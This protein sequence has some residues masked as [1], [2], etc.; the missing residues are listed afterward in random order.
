MSRLLILTAALATTLFA[1]SASAATFDANSWRADRHSVWVPG[2]DQRHLHFT[3]G[4]TFDVQP[5]AWHLEGNLVSGTDGSH[6]Q[7]SVDFSDILTGDEF[8]VLTGYDDARLKGTTWAEQHD[9]WLF[10]R[11]VTGTLKALD[12][13]WVGHEFSFVRMPGANDYLAQFGTCLNDKNCEL[14]LSTWLTFTDDKTGLE[15][16]GDINL[17]LSNPVPEPSAALVFGLG[18]VLAG[19]VVGRRDR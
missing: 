11:E 7:I 10:A 15:Y 14:G 3:D 4:A 5:D 1:V 16:R 9:D 12:G 18:S 19:S 2:L 8:G 13:D 6:W 17:E